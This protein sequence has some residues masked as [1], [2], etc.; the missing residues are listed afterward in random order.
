MAVDAVDEAI[1]VE[2]EH[3]PLEAH[4]GDGGAKSDNHNEN[5]VIDVGN[6]CYRVGASPI[7][8]IG[9]A[10]TG[11]VLSPKEYVSVDKRVPANGLSRATS[12]EELQQPSVRERLW[13][14][15]AD[16][17]GWIPEHDLS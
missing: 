14:H 9:L 12:G 16:G 10:V 3:D 4:V 5:S 17:R 8:V 13:L 2:C 15:L 7:A 6:W 11:H 1:L